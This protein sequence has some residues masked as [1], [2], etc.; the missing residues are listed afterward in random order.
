LEF[1]L[2]QI[3]WLLEGDFSPAQMWRMLELKRSEIKSQMEQERSQLQ[4]IQVLLEELEQEGKIPDYETILKRVD[5]RWVASVIGV[6]PSYDQSDPVFDRLFDDVYCYVR[7]QGA[8]N[9]GCGI[10]LYH[11]AGDDI[12][13]IQVEALAPLSNPI[14]G[15]DSVRVYE[16]PGVETAASVIHHG[17]FTT[18]GKAYQARIAWIRANGYLI[19]GPTRE[20]YLGYQRGGDRSQYV[21]EIQ[22]PLSKRQEKVMKE[23]KIVR[24]DEFLVV[25]MPYLGK[26]R[27][28]RSPSYG[29]SSSVA[30]R[31]FVTSR[32]VLRSHT[33]FAIRIPLVWLITSL[34][35]L[36]PA[37][38]TFQPGWWAKRCPPRPTWFFRRMV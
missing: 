28:M 4:R 7:R 15:S 5:P 33:E 21:T 6:I 34:P 3:S 8:R 20:L 13:S 27:T 10:A 35:C 23:A 11:E 1:S 16:L 2:E 31:R 26:M 18:I 17:S 22:F 24:L 38:R 37:W 29:R 9:P 19:T 36:S 12:E 25:G 14:P 30:S 32:P